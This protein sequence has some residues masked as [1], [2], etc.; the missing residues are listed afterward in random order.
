MLEVTLLLVEL[1]LRALPLPRFDMVSLG[2][3]W[4]VGGWWLGFAK[5]QVAFEPKKVEVAQSRAMSLYGVVSV[6]SA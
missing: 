6:G 1:S 5:L 2:W 4:L 3:G